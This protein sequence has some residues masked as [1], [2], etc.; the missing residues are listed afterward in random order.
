MSRADIELLCFVCR[1]QVR[2]AWSMPHHTV[3]SPRCAESRPGRVGGGGRDGGHGGG[4]Q[5][6]AHTR[7]SPAAGGREPHR[8]SS[9]AQ[10]PQHAA[11][12]TPRGM[13]I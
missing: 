6:A 10:R 2:A 11:A 12:S 8:G 1:G 4:A 3:P 5:G 13:S 9:R 7:L